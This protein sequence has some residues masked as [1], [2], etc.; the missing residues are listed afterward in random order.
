MHGLSCRSTSVVRG[1]S[2]PLTRFRTSG[3][4]CNRGSWQL[5]LATLHSRSDRHA[6]YVRSL[7]GFP[8]CQER[9]LLNAPCT[10]VRQSVIERAADVERRV[11]AQLSVDASERLEVGLVEAIADIHVTVGRYVG[12][13]H[14][15]RRPGVRGGIVAVEEQ[16]PVLAPSLNHAGVR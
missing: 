6:A 1:V 15:E 10:V 9:G 4:D 7:E 11:D 8:V 16:L 2:T 12:N 3:C 14:Q 5:Q 13:R